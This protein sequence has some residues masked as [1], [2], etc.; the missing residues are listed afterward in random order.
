M[1]DALNSLKSL[2]RQNMKRIF[3]REEFGEFLEVFGQICSCAFSSTTFSLSF[4]NSMKENI[5]P[6]LEKNYKNPWQRVG[7]AL[8]TIK[9][10]L[11]KLRVVPFIQEVRL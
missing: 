5:I 8:G 4:F 1:Q 9:F 3:K 2:Q 10:R 7:L 6:A 11:F